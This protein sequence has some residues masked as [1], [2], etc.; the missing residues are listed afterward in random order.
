MN[1]IENEIRGEFSLGLFHNPLTENNPNDLVG[2]VYSQETVSLQQ[3]C[4][5]AA[6]R[7][8]ADISASAMF[9]AAEMLFHE[10]EFQ[11]C[12]GFSVNL[13]GVITGHVGIKGVFDGPNDH[14]DPDRHKIFFG[15]QAG[16]ALRKLIPLIKV[17]VRGM[18]DSGLKILQIEDV[19]SGSVNDLLTPGSI[20]RVFG[21][22]IKVVGDDPEVGIFFV[23]E[24]TRSRVKVA[25]NQIETNANSKLVFNIPALP[26]GAYHIEVVT[27]YSNANALLKAPRTFKFEKALTVGAPGPQTPDITNPPAPFE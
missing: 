20:L 9:H 26:D 23:S 4:E 13:N 5:S 6:G 11:L 17:N 16:A 27:Q 25:P 24:T 3:L 18:A 15:F 21:Q 12:N 10:V 2:H 19:A 1:N 8:G 14:F 22:K 7:G